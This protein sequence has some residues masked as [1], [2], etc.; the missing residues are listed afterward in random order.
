MDDIVTILEIVAYV[1]T[2]ISN[3]ENVEKALTKAY[4]ALRRKGELFLLSF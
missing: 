2:I 4:A 1:F 3:Y